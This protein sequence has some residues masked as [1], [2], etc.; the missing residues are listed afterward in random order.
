MKKYIISIVFMLG[1]LI[2]LSVLLYPTVSD[3]FNSISQS[4]AVARYFDN[5]AGMDDTKIQE[6]L[7][8][9]QEHNKKLL[10]RQD[11]FTFTEEET[12]E[13]R[14]ML[15]TT[16]SVMGILNIDKINVSL[17]IYHGTDEGVLQIGVGHMQGTSLPVGG[18]GTHAFITGHRG[19]PSSALLSELNKLEEGDLFVLYILNETL[20]YQVDDIREVLP[21][22]IQ[23][24]SIDPDAD[25]VTLVT[26]TPYGVNTH[27][28]LVR[29]RRVEN[30]KSSG[31]RTFL[32][33]A[34]LLDRPVVILIFLIPIAFP[35][36]IIYAV[37]QCVKI[38]RKSKLSR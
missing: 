9:A 7:K 27:R 12:A 11:R 19:L 35:I 1:I 10:T 3:Y 2:G 32:A 13:Y 23:A 21:A 4:R 6:L 37:V 25:Y 26:C 33:D 34:K 36:L 15:T 17:P 24:I 8:Q 28:L 31:W 20:T 29:G 16:R 38:R 22:D 18:A 30:V 5:I 14:K